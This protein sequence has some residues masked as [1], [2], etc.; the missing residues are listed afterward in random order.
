MS[1]GPSFLG[2]AYVEWVT[3]FS[4]A[5]DNMIRH[6]GFWYTIWKHHDSHWCLGFKLWS[7]TFRENFG[8]W[9]RSSPLEIL[10]YC[11]LN[12]TFPWKSYPI[13]HLPVFLIAYSS[14]PLVSIVYS[15]LYSCTFPK[16][17]HYLEPYSNR[18]FCKVIYTFQFSS[19]V[20]FLPVA[21]YLTIYTCYY[22]CKNVFPIAKPYHVIILLL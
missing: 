1:S 6:A 19:P 18:L 10:P 9:F 4:G 3:H 11:R 12:T 8:V 17:W 21:S 20:I 13:F 15:K 5:V 16:T 22:C 14:T 2:R 7:Y